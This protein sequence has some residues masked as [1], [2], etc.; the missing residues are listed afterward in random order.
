M[1]SFDWVT[2]RAQCF[3]AT[4]FEQLRLQV[5][6]DVKTRN[7]LLADPHDAFAVVDN[8]NKFSV[9]VLGNPLR[10]VTFSLANENISVQRKGTVIC[11]ATL[12][13]ND[14][15]ECKVKIN[16]QE[17]ELWQLRKAVL[18]DLFFGTLRQ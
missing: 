7:R 4:V 11:E 18:E 3:P 12:T 16:G 9:I 6:E 5:E 1:E 13:L 17:R 8:G 14:E 10:K 2:A 15:G